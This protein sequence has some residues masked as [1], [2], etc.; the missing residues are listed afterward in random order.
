[1]CTMHQIMSAAG[2]L[3]KEVGVGC[4]KQLRTWPI[5]WAVFIVTALL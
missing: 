5:D 3:L 1:M 2:L 4:A